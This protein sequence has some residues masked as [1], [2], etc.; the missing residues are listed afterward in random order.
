[1]LASSAPNAT[2]GTATGWQ[3]TAYQVASDGSNGQRFSVNAYAVC[4]V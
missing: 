1:V 3:G 4:G 2:S